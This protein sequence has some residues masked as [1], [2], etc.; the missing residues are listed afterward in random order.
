MDNTRLWFARV[1]VLYA[2]LIFAFLAWLYVFAPLEHIDPFGISASGVPESSN[3]LR[4]G[5]GAMF[6]GMLSSRRWW[7]ARRAV[8]ASR[9]QDAASWITW[10]PSS[11]RLFA[12]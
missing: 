1:V 2:L 4:A 10:S 6:L 11:R 3:L 8:D 9:T 12:A 5:L 7:P